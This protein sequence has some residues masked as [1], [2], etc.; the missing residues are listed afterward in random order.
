MKAIPTLS[1][2]H[3]N[4]QATLPLHLSGEL[5]GVQEPQETEQTLPLCTSKAAT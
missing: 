3:A 2:S 4:A 1:P 5:M